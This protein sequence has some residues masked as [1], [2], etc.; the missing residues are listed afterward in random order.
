MRELP[1]PTSEIVCELPLFLSG[2][3]AASTIPVTPSSEGKVDAAVAP[4]R[5]SGSF[6]KRLWVQTGTH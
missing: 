5:K 3:A 4:D 2:A 6:K 1:S